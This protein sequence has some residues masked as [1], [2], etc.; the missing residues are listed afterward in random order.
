MAASGTTCKK[1]RTDQYGPRSLVP[2]PILPCHRTDAE[3]D[4][5]SDAEVKAH[6]GSKLPPPPKEKV[7]EAVVKHFVDNAQPPAIKERVSDYERCIKK[8]FLAQQEK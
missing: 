6:F 1:S 5:I 4:A 8:S 7:P 2:L 3:G